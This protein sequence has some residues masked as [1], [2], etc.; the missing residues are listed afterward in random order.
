MAGVAEVSVTA[1][2]VAQTIGGAVMAG[3]CCAYQETT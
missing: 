3:V 2:T 1:P